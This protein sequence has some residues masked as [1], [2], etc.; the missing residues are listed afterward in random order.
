[1]KSFEISGTTERLLKCQ[2]DSA[3]WS[4]AEKTEISYVNG[5]MKAFGSSLCLSPIVFLL[6]PHF[7]HVSQ[8]KALITI[9]VYH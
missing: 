5:L 8:Y 2:E 4:Y 9:E 3:L 6:N 7:Q 1:M